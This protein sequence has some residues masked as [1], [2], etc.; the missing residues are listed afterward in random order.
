MKKF[1]ATIILFSFCL[2]VQANVT[3][4]SKLYNPN[5]NAEKDIAAAI[6]KAK[7]QGKHVFIQA[8]GNW[9]GWC[10]KFNYFVTHDKDITALLKANFIVYH[11]NYSPENRNYNTF[12]K[13]GFAQRFGF[14][15]FIILDGNGNRLHTQNSAYLEEDK[16]YNKKKV[17][18]FLNAWRPAALDEKN[19][20]RDH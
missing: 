18:D 10:I 2:I 4:T 6:I 19:Y 16:S 8:G 20:T 5:A 14:P 17:L 3:D 12:K 7:Q 13:Y 11:L 1:F 15:V 9:C